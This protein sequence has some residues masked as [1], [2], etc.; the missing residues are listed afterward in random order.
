LLNGGL[1]QQISIFKPQNNK[2][3]EKILWSF[4]MVPR[5]RIELPT[6]GFSVPVFINSKILKLQAVDSIP[7]LQAIFGF[8]WKRLEIF[9]LDGHNLGTV[10]FSS[11]SISATFPKNLT[12]LLFLMIS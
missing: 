3:P 12:A 11:K 10:L 5:D 6:R 4:I 8:V 2:A 1:S 7:I 9:D